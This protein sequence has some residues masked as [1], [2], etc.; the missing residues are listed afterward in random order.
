[1]DREQFWLDANFQDAGV[2][3]SLGVCNEINTFEVKFAFFGKSNPCNICVV[4][5]SRSADWSRQEA[6]KL[7]LDF[8][9]ERKLTKMLLKADEYVPS[10]SF[11]DLKNAFAFY[12]MLSLFSADYKAMNSAGPDGHDLPFK[13]LSGCLGLRCCC[14]VEEWL[15]VRVTHPQLLAFGLPTVMFLQNVNLWFKLLSSNLRFSQ[16]CKGMVN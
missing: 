4:T 10:E 8:N 12:F 16:K 3:S 13:N 9:A 5:L 14:N 15:N 7:Y 2:G 11:K 1:M 6:P